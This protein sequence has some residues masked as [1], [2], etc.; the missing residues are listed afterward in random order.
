MTGKTVVFHIQFS[1]EHYCYAGNAI[2]L[3][4]A[5]RPE[6]EGEEFFPVQ[7][8]SI[9]VIVIAAFGVIFIVAATR[10]TADTVPQTD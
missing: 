4:K 6:I 7:V 2:V 10:I 1:V 9:S 5:V 8:H 3:V